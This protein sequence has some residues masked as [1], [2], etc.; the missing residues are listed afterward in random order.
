MNLT[1]GKCSTL[2]GMCAAEG[3]VSLPVLALMYSLYHSVEPAL[4]TNLA[5]RQR[6]RDCTVHI[7]A[8][9]AFLWFDSLHPDL[10]H[11]GK[12]LIALL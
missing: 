4:Y 7:V 12:R 10:G 6:R 3:P 2:I 5:A 11:G 8:R 1:W 9:V